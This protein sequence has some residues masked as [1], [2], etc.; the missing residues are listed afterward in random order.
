M[1]KLL[2][3]EPEIESRIPGYD[4]IFSFCSNPA[5]SFPEDY[6][7]RA[8][9]QVLYDDMYS[10]VYG[11][12][13]EKEAEANLYYR[14]VP[15]LS[16]YQKEVFQYLFF[17]AVRLR[18]FNKVLAACQPSACDIYPQNARSIGSSLSVLL[19]RESQS[20]NIQF[21]SVPPTKLKIPPRDAHGFSRWKTPKAFVNGDLSKCRIAIYSD[22]KKSA[23]VL[24]ELNP[25]ET[26]IFQ[27]QPA[28]R[29]IF[30]SFKHQVKLY[31][32]LRLEKKKEH[33]PV[34]KRI[35]NALDQPGW[36]LTI[37]QFN[38]GPRLI[39]NL[40]ERIETQMFGLLAEIDAI[41]SFFEK[42]PQLHSV[43][44]DEDISPTRMAFCHIA[45]QYRVR[46]FIESHGVLGDKHGYAPLTAD[47]T[48]VWGYAQRDKLISWG[49]PDSRI[50]VSGCSWHEHY[51]RLNRD[52]LKAQVTKELGIKPGSQVILVGFP[53]INGWRLYFENQRKQ[54][55]KQA[56]AVLLKAVERYPIHI[57]LKV[58]PRDSNK[59]YYVKTLK[60][61]PHKDRITLLE[62]YNALKLMPIADFVI[63]FGSTF[64][65]EAFSVGKNV[66]MLYENIERLYDEF[67]PF[68]MFYHA[69][70]PDEL[71][72]QIEMLIQ[73]T[74]QKKG[75]W[76][77]ARKY[78]LNE[79]DALPPMKIIAN[80]LMSPPSFPE[81]EGGM[82]CRKLSTV[83]T[84]V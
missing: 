73:D 75:Q 46:T 42:V 17:A 68:D 6:I 56:M 76:D 63:S 2:I 43:F 51:K 9:A 8:E 38:L 24:K 55:I 10:K 34:L 11:L 58:R 66:V 74:N 48:F 54:Y 52:D 33:L 78:C 70:S 7:T 35:S 37:D 61:A 40:S 47:F 84:K 82:K 20:A 30:R 59:K 26:I 32:I 16:C 22:Y 3:L 64:T 5:D 62:H 13:S 41:H 57:I 14:G 23:D 77:E 4:H 31:Q 72:K 79:G 44:L 19:D 69:D 45:K 1:K 65:V 53:A 39:R 71:M 28:I 12:L 50:I 27:N 21:L 29:T 49:V 25:K 18:L 15:L 80:Y 36:D 60:D 81:Q 83:F 67:K